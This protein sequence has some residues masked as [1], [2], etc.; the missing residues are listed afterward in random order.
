MPSRWPNVVVMDKATV[1]LVDTRWPEY[2]LGAPL[3]SPSNR[4]RKLL[5]SDS[6]EA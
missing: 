1:A 5:L 3:P 6:A 4:Y 2:G